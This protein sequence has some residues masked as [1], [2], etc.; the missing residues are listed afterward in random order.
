MLGWKDQAISYASQVFGKLDPRRRLVVLT[1]HRVEDGAL[2]RS[3]H[4]SQHFDYLA[5]N[6]KT[7]LPSQ[8]SEEQANPEGR[9][10]AMVVI[11]D[12]H[13]DTYQHIFPLA[14]TYNVPITIATPTDF[15]FRNQWLWFDKLY[16]LLARQGGN[17]KFRV[18]EFP[19]ELDQAASI[20]GLKR[21]LKT[22]LPPVRDRLLDEMSL[23]MKSPFPLVP[24]EDY[25]PVSMV[26]MR[27]MLASG[28]V[29]ISSHSVSHPI[30]SL[31]A[32]KN[33]ENE[34][35]QSKRELEEF[36]GNRI[37][38]FCYPNGE[39]GDFDARTTAVVRRAGYQ[40]AFTTVPGRNI[41]NKMDM[42]TIRRVHIHPRLSNFVK[43][44][45]KIWRM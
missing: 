31:L 9:H 4:V 43:D 11:D 26:E 37:T 14:K 8:F 34:I 40:M 42:F 2:I 22:S 6:Y 5:R 13:Y 17:R 3:G 18:G 38:S 21:L 44:T 25:R 24:T 45:N 33:L 27:E 7:I 15:F 23:N 30:V 20:S 41:I 19:L 32:D 29:E 35:S 1:L 36:A 16:W 28:L 12:C 39:I 10:L